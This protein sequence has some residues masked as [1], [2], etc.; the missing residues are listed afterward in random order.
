MILESFVLGLWIKISD[1]FCDELGKDSL[2]LSTYGVFLGYIIST[3]TFGQLFLASAAAQIFAGKIDKNT[4]KIALLLTGITIGYL[5]LPNIDFL[6]VLFFIAAFFDEF[7][8]HR[9]LLPLLTLTTLKPTYII[10][11]FAADIGYRVMARLLKYV[12]IK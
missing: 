3:F 11:L 8:P 10:P 1:W 12:K 2:L 4:H 7:L 9:P 6:F 5:G